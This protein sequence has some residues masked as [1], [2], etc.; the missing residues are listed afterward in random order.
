MK[1]A[2]RAGPLFTDLYELTMAASYFAH[3]VF[4]TATFSLFIRENYLKRNFFVAAGLEDVL[5]ELAAFRFSEQDIKYLQTT[6]IFSKDFLSYLAG[7]RFSGKIFAMPE[8][9]IFFANEPVLEVTAPIIEAQLIETF[10]LNTIGFQSMIASKAARCVHIAGN[11]PLIDFS[12]RRTQGQDAGHNVARSTYL[13]GFAATS[14]VLAGQMY[15]IPI[16][17]TMAH[18]YIEAFSGDLAAFSA[19]SE[20]FPD[21][22]I[23]LIDTYNTIDGAKHAVTVAKQMKQKG[24]S[25]IGVR[26]DSG[27]MVDLS[28]KVRKIFDDAGLSDVKIFASSGFD[29]FKIAKVI[30]QGAKIDAFGVGTKVGVSADA[31][32][33]DVVYKMVHF[34]DRDVRKLSPGKITLAG[35]KQVFRKSDPNGRY[36]EDIIG[37]RDDIVDQGTPLLK[38][39]MENGEILQPYPQLQA[40]QESF[41]KNFSLLDERYKSILEYYA[42][43][44]KL[45]K[46]LKMLQEST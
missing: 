30:A 46:H 23:F 42:Y 31:P 39:V 41:K 20:T 14:N 29:E 16:S 40:I 5:N 21:N 33:L 1:K 38:K 28:Q 26:L 2:H 12:L 32:Y 6:G 35:E 17:G 10:L 3:Q 22:S 13:A 36:L 43:P 15:G 25:L 45:S 34:K 4:S 8:G 11:R 44:V 9:T 19:Y 27:D 24:H 18:S 7:L 37:L